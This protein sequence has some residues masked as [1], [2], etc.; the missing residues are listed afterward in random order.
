MFI[1]HMGIKDQKNLK[2]GHFSRSA[3]SVLFSFTRANGFLTRIS[4]PR[5]ALV[6]VI[7]QTLEFNIRIHQVSTKGNKTLLTGFLEL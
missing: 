1:P 5:K 6:S 7:I 4:I 2:Y 3:I